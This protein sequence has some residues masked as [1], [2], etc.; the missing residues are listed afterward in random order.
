MRT[1]VA[2][3]L[4]AVFLLVLTSAGFAQLPTTNRLI[5]YYPFNG[6][7]KD[8]S[9]FINDCWNYATLSSDRF[10]ALNSAISFNGTN[11]YLRAGTSQTYLNFPD[12]EFTISFWARLAEPWNRQCLIAVDGPYTPSTW[13]IYAGPPPGETERFGLSFYIQSP[14]GSG[15]YAPWTNQ[16]PSYNWRQVV[17][18]KV[19]T[20]YEFFVNGSLVSS[21]IG[22][23][24]L[25][26]DNIGVLYMG[27]ASQTNY[28]QGKIDDVR[29]YDRGLSNEEIFDLFTAEAGPHTGIMKAVQP[30]FWNLTISNTYQLQTS[31]NLVV[32]KDYGVP[33]V[34]TNTAMDYQ[35]FWLVDDWD[36][37][38]FRLAPR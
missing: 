22:P 21:G 13:G 10:N 35:Q 19:S 5:G 14:S 31:A 18:R 20:Q 12:G 7:T 38:F 33:F 16:L 11:Q 34:A 28:A 25:P 1:T 9:F 24:A 8:E 17:V 37:V 3:P 30:T 36:S 6:N 29:I 2:F 26:Q 4:T 15:C 27:S 23:P 32:W